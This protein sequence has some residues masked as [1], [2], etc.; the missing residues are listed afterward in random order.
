MN[1]NLT[2]AIQ[3]K[4]ILAAMYLVVFAL[5]GG[6]FELFVLCL[7]FM[8]AY[9]LVVL[10]AC[11]FSTCGWILYKH[12]EKMERNQ[13]CE[14][15]PCMTPFHFEWK[16]MT[17]AER[18]RLVNK[19]DQDR[20][21]IIADEIDLE[22]NCKHPGFRGDQQ[23]TDDFWNEIDTV[24]GV[25]ASWFWFVVDWLERDSREENN[26]FT[27]PKCP[28]D[29]LIKIGSGFVWGQNPSITID[30]KKAMATG[31]LR[32]NHHANNNRPIR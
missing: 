21:A 6:I 4:L 8:G 17:D 19:M 13:T 31:Y 25:D 15:P 11:A 16:G 32:G 14:N 5:I 9:A 28:F 18:Q 30:R 24:F 12:S 26:R 3:E 1:A 27:D 10:I 20:L 23:R 7:G 29:P 22:N 2:R